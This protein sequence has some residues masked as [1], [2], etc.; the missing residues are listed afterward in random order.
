MEKDDL[1]A[2]LDFDSEDY[3]TKAMGTPG[4]STLAECRRRRNRAMWRERAHAQ[5]GFKRGGPPPPVGETLFSQCSGGMTE[6]TAFCTGTGTLRSS[7]PLPRGTHSSGLNSPCL[8][9]WRICQSSMPSPL[10]LKQ[11]RWPLPTISWRIWMSSMVSRWPFRLSAQLSVSCNSGPTSPAKITMIAWCR[12]RYSCEKG[13][14]TTFARASWQGWPRNTFTL[15]YSTSTALS[16][17]TWSID[18]MPPVWVCLLPCRK[19]SRMT[20]SCEWGTLPTLHSM[21]TDS[22]DLSRR[23]DLS[24]ARRKALTSGLSSWNRKKRATPCVQCSCF[25]TRRR[26]QTGG[27][28]QRPWYQPLDGSGLPHR[29]GPGGRL[30]WCMIRTLLQLLRRRSSL[31]RMHQITTTAWIARDT[32]PR[33][34]KPKRGHWRQ[35]RPCPPTEEG[36]RQTR[37][38]KAPR[39]EPPVEG[40]SHKTPFCYWN[41][42]ALSRWLGPENLGWA[43]IDGRCTRILLDTGTRVNSITPAYVRKHKLK[44]GSVAALD[45]SLNPFGRRVPLVGVGGRTRTLGYVLMMKTR[46]HSWWM[47]LPPCSGS[48]CQLCSGPPP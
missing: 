4:R 33:G 6:M 28:V 8:K 25:R 31:E 42:D 18:Q 3:D 9:P 29:H 21:Q 22:P 26:V 38:P 30:C 24:I 32:R 11:T 39:Q 46:W 14:W 7:R 13:I 5:L 19:M 40:T 27:S 2:E 48:E 34:F 20:Y 35:G 15:G 36:E 16:W 37:G 12:S 47:T 23:T 43:Q 41:Q 45:H 10:T 17:R 1:A 44:V